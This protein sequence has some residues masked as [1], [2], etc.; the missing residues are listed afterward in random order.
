MKQGPSLVVRLTLYPLALILFLLI[1]AY[2]VFISAGY[3]IKLEDGQIK[4]SKTG[5]I[6]VATR[7]GEAKVTLDGEV[8]DKKTSSISFFKLKINRMAPGEH[9]LVVERDGYETWEGDVNVEAG[10]VSWLDYLIL[11]PMERKADPYNISGTIESTITSR[12]QK[13]IL[14][15]SLDKTQNIYSFWQINTENK[16][17][18]KIYEA[19][20]N[21]GETISLVSYSNNNSR[22]LYAKTDKSKKVSY[23]TAEAKANGSSS[24]I[25][26]LF[27]NGATNYTYSPYNENE[28]Y[29]VRDKNLYKVNIPDKSQTAVLAKDVVGIY[30]NSRNLLMIQKSDDNYGLWQV[31]NNGDLHNIIKSLPAAKE[32]KVSYLESQKLYLIHNL[33]DQDLILYGN[34]IKNPTLETIAKKVESYTVSPNEEK[35]GFLS[36]GVYRVYDLKK[37]QYFNAIQSKDIKIV[38]WFSDSA[39]LL[40]ATNTGIYMVNF[41]G[42]Y[43]VS[44]FPALNPD[45]TLATEVGHNIYFTSDTAGDVDLYSFSL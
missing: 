20:L 7:P 10:F 19:K 8:Y 24:N 12:D 37:E 34:E 11:V 39:N 25:S 21:S 2:V 30:P 27:S 6:I 5:I 42:Y 26:S 29:F 31:G 40:Y 45:I 38:D 32:Y 23:I 14:V 28:L 18:E 22:F 41:N 33:D 44:L 1:S 4:T 9:H 43:N 3:E 36:N 35:V 17:Q 16:Q 15:Y 13:R